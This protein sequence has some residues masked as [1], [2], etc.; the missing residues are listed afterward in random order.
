M[1]NSPYWVWG[2]AAFLALGGLIGYFK[3]GSWISLTMALIF[4]IA[5]SWSC[6]LF[7][8]GS[9]LGYRATVAILNLILIVFGVRFFLTLK[10][11]PATIVIATIGVLFIVLFNG[12]KPKHPAQ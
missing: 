9:E 3:A 10:L 2:Y 7:N 5:L 12:L 1:K 11:I 4:S 6:W 8:K